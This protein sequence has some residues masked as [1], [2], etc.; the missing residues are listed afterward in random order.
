[1]S[2]DACLDRSAEL[3]G[4]EPLEFA[5]GDETSAAEFDGPK[6]TLVEELVDRVVTHS[7]V[8]SCAPWRDRQRHEGGRVRLALLWELHR[9]ERRGGARAL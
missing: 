9:S 6:A 2:H 5:D 4:E 8:L 1:M 7:E 3:F